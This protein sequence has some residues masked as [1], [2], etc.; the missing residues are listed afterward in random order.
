MTRTLLTDFGPGMGFAWIIC[1]FLGL[2]AILPSGCA[3][4]E[5]KPPSREV[6][7]FFVSGQ[8]ADFLGALCLSSKGL[9][10]SA[11]SHLAGVRYPP[12]TKVEVLYGRPSR[13]FQS[14][15]VLECESNSHFQSPEVMA[16][17]RKKARE[18]G[19]DA[20]IMCRPGSGR[21]LPG[22]PPSAKMQAVAIKYK[23]TENQL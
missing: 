20:I 11:Y 19:A 12:T 15:A 4:I 22:M 6:Q 8:E 13:P 2:A 17:F 16:G 1:L 9:D 3:E 23:L 7:T 5:V 18:I 10:L 14:F 21:V